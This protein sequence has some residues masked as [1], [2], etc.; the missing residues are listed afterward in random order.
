MSTET[1]SSETCVQLVFNNER[2]NKYNSNQEF[3]INE[4]QCN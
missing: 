1:I 4:S 2:G 3:K